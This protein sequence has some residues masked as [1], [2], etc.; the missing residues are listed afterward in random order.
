MDPKHLRI[1]LATPIIAL[2]VIILFIN[3]IP[4]PDEIQRS[5]DVILE[6]REVLK[7]GMSVDSVEDAVEKFQLPDH[8][9]FYFVNESVALLKRLGVSPIHENW[10]LRLDFQDGKLNAIKIGTLDNQ[11]IRPSGSPEN[12]TLDARAGVMTPVRDS[13]GVALLRERFAVEGGVQLRSN[14]VPD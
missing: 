6:V 2:A 9:E 8:M 12:K 10:L 13:S 3:L 14:R 5:R 4:V 7:P 1:L 11:N